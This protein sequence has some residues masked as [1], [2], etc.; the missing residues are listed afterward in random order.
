MK[1][2]AVLFAL[3]V[4]LFVASMTV[5][6]C[7]PAVACARPAYPT[8]RPRPTVIVVPVVTVTPTVIPR[9]NGPVDPFPF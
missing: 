4:L 5:A 7:R 2:A 8:R 3:A 6:Q 9:R 1:K